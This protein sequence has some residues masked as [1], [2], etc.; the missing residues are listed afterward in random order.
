VD[1]ASLLGG[2]GGG[3]GT[4]GNS[5]SS[6]VSTPVTTTAGGGVNQNFNLGSLGIGNTTFAIPSWAWYV[7][8]GVAVL[9]VWRKVK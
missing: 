2:G 4:Y 9:Y 3:G 6:G 8:A 5:G 7:A 1:W